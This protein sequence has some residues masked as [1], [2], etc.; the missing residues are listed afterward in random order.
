MLVRELSRASLWSWHTWGD[1]GCCIPIAGTA[2]FSMR[3][4]PYYAPGTCKV[5][6]TGALGTLQQRCQSPARFACS[7]W[8]LGIG[9]YKGK[10]L[11]LRK[12]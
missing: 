8:F 11:W 1:G 6:G 7:G 2:R 9:C 4:S 10:G 5:S 3:S 12:S